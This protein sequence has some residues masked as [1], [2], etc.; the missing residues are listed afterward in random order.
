[1]KM[2]NNTLKK[3]IK[4]YREAYDAIPQEALELDLRV[5][6]KTIQVLAKGNPVS[7]TQLADIW[8]MPL[9]QVRG[10]L[11]QAEESGRVEIND[12]G[13]LVGAVLS[14]NPTQHQISMD[15][16]H[17]YSWCAYDAMYTPGVVGKPAQIVSDDPV[18]GGRIQLSIT[19]DGVETIRPESAVVSVIDPG[20]NMS[21]GPESTRCTHM[22]FFE[23]RESAEQ[24]KQDRTGISI[25]TVSEIFELVKEFQINPARRLGLV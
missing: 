5:T 10:I 13:E 9:D 1:M 2:Q 19:P 20:G 4:K 14:L 24:W 18:T 23:S 12:R 3:V 6:F 25:L 22:L 21:A 16:Q 11:R 15:N 17:L 8:G 7:P